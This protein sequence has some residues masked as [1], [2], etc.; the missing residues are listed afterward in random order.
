M[1]QKQKEIAESIISTMKEKGG[2]MHN[3]DSLIEIVH[4]NRIVII[5]ELKDLDLIEDVHAG[6]STYR[7]TQK[8]WEFK[9]FDEYQQEKELDKS[10]KNL[11]FKQLKGSIFQVKYWWL[12]LLINAIISFIVALILKYIN[13]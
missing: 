3:V 4:E 10:I 2:L 11:T 13:L 6:S 8:G 1:N 12:F 7:L 9:G 5:R